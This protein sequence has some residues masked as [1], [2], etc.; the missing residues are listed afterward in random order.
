M[1]W[2]RF[3]V[4]AAVAFAVIARSGRAE[5]PAGEL[6]DRVWSGHPVSFAF[7][8]E[9]EHQFIAYYDAERRI[10]LV[11]RK[12][13]DE[14]W[15]RLQPPGAPAP[16][17]Q[18]MSNVTGWDSHNYL[19]LAL[20][21]NGCVHLAG[22]MHVD[23]LV[24]Y[25]TRAPFDVA[26]L[27]RLDRMT[28][29][30]EAR[31]TYPVFFKNAAGDLLFRYRD[32]SSGNGSDLYNLYEP[33]TRT[34][35]RQLD[36][37]LLEGE[38][39]RNAYALDPVLGPDGR[40][41]LVW[42][43]RESPDCATNNHL[44]YARSR[45]F[46]HWENSRGEPLALPITRATGDVIDAA[47]PHDG[48]INMT[49]NLGFDAEK[50]PVVVYHRYDAQHH[51]QIYAARPRVAGGWDVR[52][53]SA[54]GF[55]WAFSGNGSI[56]AEVALGAPRLAPDGTLLVDY[57]T[58][59]AGDGRWR[60]RADPLERI[61]QLPPAPHALPDELLRAQHPGMEVQSVVARDHGRRYVLRW[62]TLPRNRDEPR[63]AAP[64]PTELRLIELPEAET[65]DTER[66]G[67]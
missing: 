17:E 57:A 38:G 35:R 25:R 60:L 20:D 1:H 46:I 11:G 3:P 47:Q 18:R 65:S 59:A 39:Q 21:R 42:M 19:R 50:N 31:C 63:A 37:P 52:A 30:H 13:G 10:T 61:A 40:F 45:D 14:K 55:T 41:H 49:F 5:T 16:R 64:P 67:S 56:A 22:N 33:A 51:S 66:I 9:R 26:T 43:W 36:T 12:I 34:W 44:S 62:E 32:G 58:R 15:T 29:E 28:G 53:I 48:L 24:Y 7:L 6:I 27:E 4:L 23:P 2:L 54:W 8:V